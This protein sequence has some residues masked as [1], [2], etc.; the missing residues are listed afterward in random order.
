M[1]P[2]VLRT[3][4]LLAA[5]LAIVGAAAFCAAP[6]AF[7][8]G[9]TAVPNGATTAGSPARSADGSPTINSALA[10]PGKTT[11]F[12]RDTLWQL[13]LPTGSTVRATDEGGI[14]FAEPGGT[15]TARYA[16]VSVTDTTGTDHRITWTLEGT[17]LHQHV[18]IAASSLQGRLEP[19]L[20]AQSR[21]FWDCV[22]EKGKDNMVAGIIGGCVLGAET[23][24]AP[25]A[26]VGG[27]AGG[28]GGVATGL[29]KC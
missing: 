22:G 26:A 7:A 16:P 23:G 4:H 5:G 20:S 10:E 13:A 14:Q 18:D 6:N 17:T 27:F 19:A 29:F 2:T 11:T 21:G 12:Y 3:A 9:T 24:C 25:G 1:N 15:V 8:A 28:L